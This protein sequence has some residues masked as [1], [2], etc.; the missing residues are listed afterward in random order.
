MRK[1]DFD[2]GEYYHIY[3]RGVSKQNIFVD[4]K[5]YWKFFDCLR[6]LNNTTYYGERLN[7]LGLSKHSK[8]ELESSD[9]KQLNS[10]LKQKNN[11]VDLISYSFSPNHFHLILKQQA[12]R[13]ISNFM[14]K[15][16]LSMTKFFNK[17]YGHSGHIFQGPFKA[18]HIDSNEY[19]LWL[20]GYV[21]G[22]VEIHG[23]DKTE[24]YSWSSYRAMLKELGSFQRNEL[25]SLSGLS[26][27]SGLDIV[28][29]QFGSENEFKKFVQRVIIESRIK[30]EMEKYFLE[31]L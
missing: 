25:S 27:L 22:N 14:Q 9:F 11:V 28:F 17:K 5:D 21:N 19:F 7:V 2:N 18:I 26:V 3:N 15:V 29:S 10:F 8:R 1:I 12:D 23:L 4:E 6:D 24:S 30:K 20:L 31:D 16:G 13:G